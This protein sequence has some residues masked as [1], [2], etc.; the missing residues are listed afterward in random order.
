MTRECERPARAYTHDVPGVTSKDVDRELR[1]TLWPDLYAEGFTRRTGRTAWQD[2]DDQVNVVQI[3]SFNSYNA[4][5]LGVSTVSFQVGLGVLPRCRTTEHTPSRNGLLLPRDAHCEFRC[6]LRR[7]LRQPAGGN[8]TIWPIAI[9]GADIEV[10]VDDAREVLMSDGLSWFESLDG[11]GRMLWTAENV[12]NGNTD[13]TWGMGRL[14][15]PHRIALLTDLHR[16]VFDR[17][18]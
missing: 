16:A 6:G 1:R 2:R 7:R 10:T 17:D 14:G 3:S 15:S 12:E 4:G 5:V 11:L 9:D 8:P 18:S 13:Q